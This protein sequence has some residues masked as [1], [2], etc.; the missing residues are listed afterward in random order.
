MKKYFLLVI[1]STIILAISG[2]GGGGSGDGGSKKN[3]GETNTAGISGVVTLDV[4][5]ANTNIVNLTASPNIQNIQTVNTQNLNTTH[6]TKV[7]NE[8]IIKLRSSLS[9]SQIE[10]LLG[11][12]G[13]RVIRKISKT[14]NIYLV[15]T[16]GSLTKINTL[17]SNSDI[18]YTEDNQYVTKCVIP[19][20][21]YFSR[22]W[23]YPLMNIPKAWDTGMGSSSVI[24]AVIDTGI[25]RNHPE[26]PADRLIIL[27][28]SDIVNNDNDPSDDDG[29]G[30]H[31]AG[32][33]A[34]KTSNGQGI[35][36]IAPNVKIMPIKVF[37]NDGYGTIA[38]VVE[39][40]NLAV[41]NGARIINLSLTSTVYTPV[42][43][44]SP[45]LKN[46]ID[47]AVLKGA[48]VIAAA[49][50][51]NGKVNFPANYE[52]VI[53][54]GAVNP[55][56]KKAS[57]SN[58]GPEIFVVAPGGCGQLADWNTQGILSCYIPAST[59]TYMLGTSMAAPHISGLV[60]L[61]YSRP[62][63]ITNPNN[64]NNSNIIKAR[65]QSHT[66]DINFDGKDNYYGY[67]LPDA[68]AVLTNSAPEM[69]K[70][71]VFLGKQNRLKLS[72]VYNVSASG[73]FTIY[74]LI[75]TTEYL[76][77]FEDNN[78]NNQIDPG[79]KYGYTRVSLSNNTLT[80]NA[81]ISLNMID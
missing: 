56:L 11:H 31:V 29:H 78:G 34:A 4:S 3:R 57:F 36:G 35:A 10:Q 1:I 63:I 19:N 16:E 79:E 2:C 61:M 55:D 7:P 18:L 58:Y 13:A 38:D 68:Y 48:T 73:N 75:E 43:F 6:E 39:G 17:Q 20:D 80:S 5:Q 47:N 71:K 30:T 41:N 37:G 65:I 23:N 21:P 40:I 74:N 25:N 60:A 33:I 49:G 44:G 8:K 59:Y 77:A 51:D 76:W 9:T 45:T 66:I 14:D 81:A 28:R 26:F 12:M 69:G 62:D 72:P 70:V 27:P 46:A 22:Q 54:V 42:A 64:P 15:K 67:G 24:V 50:N 53:A 32:I 52:K